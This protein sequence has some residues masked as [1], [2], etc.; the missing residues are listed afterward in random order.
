MKG[1]S[2]PLTLVV[3][4]PG[5]INGV[6]LFRQDLLDFQDLLLFS[7]FSD[8]TVKKQSASQNYYSRVI[9]DVR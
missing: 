4:N 9:G 2:L 5:K 3:L 1:S 7:Q 8:E 6:F